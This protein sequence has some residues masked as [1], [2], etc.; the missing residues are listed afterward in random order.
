MDQIR[1]LVH[2]ALVLAFL[3]VL[4]KPQRWL[5]P[6]DAFNAGQRPSM[7]LQLCIAVVG[8]WTGLIVLDAATYLLVSLVLIGGLFLQQAS[9]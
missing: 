2:V 7:V 4:F 6:R 5:A 8:L 1:V 3:L 9:A